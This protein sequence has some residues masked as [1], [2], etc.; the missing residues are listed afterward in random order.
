[1]LVG[2]PVFY[3]GAFRAQQEMIGRRFDDMC[4][5]A[6]SG[7]SHANFADQ[8]DVRLLVGFVVSDDESGCVGFKRFLYEGPSSV[9]PANGP[10]D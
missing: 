5:A 2:V 10:S 3:G 1:M 9:K 4:K 7:A 6:E 8:S